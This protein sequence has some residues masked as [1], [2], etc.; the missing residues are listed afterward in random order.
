MQG[1]ERSAILSK[2]DLQFSCST[3][4]DSNSLNKGSSSLC[5]RMKELLF[6]LFFSFSFSVEAT[7]YS[8][9]GLVIG[10]YN[11]VSPACNAYGEYYVGEL[12]YYISFQVVDI[13]DLLCTFWWIIDENSHDGH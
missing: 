5:K 8:I 10:W 4:K 3:G 7:E 12:P 1:R 9:S 11:S 6:I 2:S 13:Q